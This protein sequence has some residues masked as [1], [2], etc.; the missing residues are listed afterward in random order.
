[1]SKANH[2]EVDFLVICDCNIEKIDSN[3]Y[4][5]TEHEIITWVIYQTW[6]R[7]N[8]C[9]NKCRKYYDANVDK[10]R[11]NINKFWKKNLKE[12][13]PFTPTTIVNINNN[14]YICKIVDYKIINDKSVL[15]VSTCG[16][17]GKSNYLSK[18]LPSGDF[19]NVNLN[20]DPCGCNC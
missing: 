1:M 7:T 9:A 16:F 8:M 12:C 18:E 3:E 5:I 15:I 20:I 4:R 6:S 19:K 2:P 17:E 14:H 11:K 10:L 13:N